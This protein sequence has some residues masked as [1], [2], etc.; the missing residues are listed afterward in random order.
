[1]RV[2]VLNN[3]SIKDIIDS[4]TIDEKIRNILNQVI[5]S[6]DHNYVNCICTIFEMFTTY[7]YRLDDENIDLTYEEIRDIKNNFNSIKNS[8]YENNIII[9]NLFD[10]LYTLQ[11]NDRTKFKDYFYEEFY[12]RLENLLGV[13]VAHEYMEVI[14]ENMEI[15]F[16]TVEGSIINSYISEEHIL[17]DNIAIYIEI[18][19]DI[20]IFYIQ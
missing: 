5:L 6:Y 10:I 11:N 14:F 1:M 2:L 17:H 15:I 20:I 3:K 9:S 8:I 4:L 13:N 19:N 12:I 7:Y 18:V 16:S